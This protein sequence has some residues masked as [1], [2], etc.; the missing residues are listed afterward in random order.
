MLVTSHCEITTRIP[1]NRIIFEKVISECEAMCNVSQGV[2]LRWGF[3]NTNPKQ[4]HCVL[5]TALS[6]L[7]TIEKL[8][9]PLWSSGQSS[10][11]QIQRYGFDSRGTLSLVSTIEGLLKKKT[12][13]LG[14]IPRAN[15]TDRATAACRRSDCH[16]DWA[17]P[18][19][20]QTL[21]LT[22]STSYG[23]SRTQ[24]MEFVFVIA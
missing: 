12:K 2:L 7:L 15:Y 22:S 11:L 6:F 21:A 24:A 10:W 13:L 5:S 14:L 3:L 16:A 19:Y 17:T 8:V 4:E 23:R 20:P 18:L 9:P 1:C